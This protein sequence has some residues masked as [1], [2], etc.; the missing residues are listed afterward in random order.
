MAR[1]PFFG[2]TAGYFV[3]RDIF[4]QAPVAQWIEQWIPNPCA[5]GPIPAGGTRPF[6]G[7]L[8]FQQVTPGCCQ[9]G[10]FADGFS[11]LRAPLSFHALTDPVPD[12]ARFSKFETPNPV[13]PFPT[14]VYP[15][16]HPHRLYLRVYHHASVCDDRAGRRPV[17]PE[18]T[19]EKKLTPAAASATALC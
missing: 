9:P 4:F 11:G 8:R 6:C 15:Y 18:P 3:I 13:L 12:A 14:A 2:S 17:F 10:L 5:A 19:G 7:A 1:N 16:R